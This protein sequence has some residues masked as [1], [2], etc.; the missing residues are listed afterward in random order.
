MEPER[1][2]HLMYI[3]TSVVAI[4]EL[5]TDRCIVRLRVSAGG[6]STATLLAPRPGLFLNAETPDVIRRLVPGGGSDFETAP[7]DW[8]AAP[9][10]FVRNRRFADNVLGWLNG[11]SSEYNHL[12]NFTPHGFTFY[13]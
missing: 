2:L 11:E 4:L 7:P 12:Y 8:V 1:Q 13:G 3:P 10:G 6:E 5:P 9:L